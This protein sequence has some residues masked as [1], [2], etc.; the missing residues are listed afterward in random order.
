MQRDALHKTEL[1]MLICLASEVALKLFPPDLGASLRHSQDVASPAPPFP[2]SVPGAKAPTCI[3]MQGE[4]L[5]VSEA[6]PKGEV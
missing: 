3:R 6:G 5:N 4:P 2:E 1:G